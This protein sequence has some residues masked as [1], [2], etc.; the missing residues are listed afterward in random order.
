VAVVQRLDPVE[1][2]QESQDRLLPPP[3]AREMRLGPGGIDGHDRQVFGRGRGIGELLDE[4]SRAVDLVSI[5][6]DQGERAPPLVASVRRVPARV[7]RRCRGP[8]SPHRHK[9]GTPRDHVS[10]RPPTESV[11]RPLHDAPQV[12][13]EARTPCRVEP[14]DRHRH[15]E[16]AGLD[17]IFERHVPPRAPAGERHDEPPQGLDQRVP[18]AEPALASHAGRR[19]AGSVDHPIHLPDEPGRP[20]G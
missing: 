13:G 19:E 5:E 1:A 20:E 11:H 18:H 17:P 6:R 3:E 9:T 2:E 16:D 7:N 8:G 14:L 4:R 10:R 12:G 15:G